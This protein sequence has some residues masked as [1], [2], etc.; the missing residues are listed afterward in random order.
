M[1]IVDMIFRMIL[2]RIVHMGVNKGIG[3][4]SGA[5]RKRPNRADED[6]HADE[7]WRGDDRPVQ[8]TKGRNRR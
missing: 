3:V 5:L 2:R 7:M 8:R 1:N 6:P 4:A